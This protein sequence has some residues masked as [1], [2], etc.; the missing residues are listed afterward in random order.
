MMILGEK[1]SD[2][3]P[4]TPHTSKFP[5]SRAIAPLNFHESMW[6]NLP[7]GIPLSVQV[8]NY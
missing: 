2:R 3:T 4:H 8:S 1:L 5:T 7:K 6:R